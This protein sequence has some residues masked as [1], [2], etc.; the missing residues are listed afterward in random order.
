MARPKQLPEA[1]NLTEDQ[2]REMLALTSSA[3]SV[4]LKL[5]VSEEHRYSTL[6]ALGIDPLDAYLRQIFFFDTADLAL[7]RAGVVARARRSQGRPDDS[8]VKLRPVEPSTLEAQERK[9][10]NF[11]VEWTQCPAASCARRRTRAH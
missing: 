5:T 1:P 11:V 2:V 6:Q 10:K 4:E 7:D 8:V 9:S 3:D